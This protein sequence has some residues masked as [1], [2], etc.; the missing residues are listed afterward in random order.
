MDDGSPPLLSNPK[1]V[2][3]TVVQTCGRQR[4]T[5]LQLASPT[6]AVYSPPPTGNSFSA[7]ANT[8]AYDNPGTRA[9]NSDNALYKAV[10]ITA[11][12]VVLSFVGKIRSW[13]RLLLL[14]IR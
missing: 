1:D 4:V 3:F 2:N 12:E 10:I 5:P 7:L 13:M 6:Q 11:L 8:D 9:T 14:L